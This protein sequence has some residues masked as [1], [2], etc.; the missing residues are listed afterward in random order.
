MRLSKIK[1]AG[2]K[3]F[4]D[5]TTIS[6]PS[7]LVGIVGPNGCG[8]SNVIDAV[9][10]VMGES[11]AKHLRGDSMADVIFNG[12][13]SRKPVGAATIELC[14]DNSDGSIGGEYAQYSEIAIKRS[15]GR[16]GLSQYFLN[17]TRCRRKDITDIFLGTGLGAR[18]YAII[19]QGMVSRLVDAKPDDMRTYIEEAAGISKYKERRRE[20]ENRIQ[21]TRDNLARLNDLREEVAKQIDY[22]QR[23]AKT[24][25]R[26]K[27]LKARERQLEAELFA[28]RLR[29]LDASLHQQRADLGRNE[30][31]LEAAVAE[32][33]GVEAEIIVARER[34]VG[35]TESFNA[36]QARFYAVQSE[37]SRLEQTIAHSRELAERRASDLEQTRS[38]LAEIAIEIERDSAQLADLDQALE[39]LDPDIARARQA[40]AAAVARFRDAEEALDR[41]QDAWHAFNLELK[42]L[43]Q[44]TQVE[45]TRIEHLTAQSASVQRQQETLES[46]RGGLAADDFEQQLQDRASAETRLAGEV[47][48]VREQLAGI[49]S[50]IEQLRQRERELGAELEG[51]LAELSSQ[52]GQ[53]STLMAVQQAALGAEQG[54]LTRWLAGRHLD[55][56]PRLAQRLQVEEGWIL[57]VETVLGD[58]L[59]AVCVAN[60]AEHLE[61]LPDAQVHLIS[62]QI[63]E[64]PYD[65]GTLLERVQRAGS[66]A[67]ILASVRVADSLADAVAIQSR[68]GVHE[69]V[70]TADGIWLGHGWARINRG[71]RSAGGLLSRASDLRKLEKA[72]T[73]NEALAAT[74]ERARHE[75]WARLADL[76]QTRNQTADRFTAANREHAEAVAVLEG[77][78]QQFSRARERGTLIEQTSA[79]VRREFEELN[80]AIAGAKARLE[81]ARTN[82][83]AQNARQPAL[84]LQQQELLDAYNAAGAQVESER[85]AL[86]RINVEYEGRRVARESLAAALAKLTAQSAQLA[87]R[88]ESLQAE[89]SGA[90]E[91]LAETRRTLE[92]RLADQLLIEKDLTQIREALEAVESALRA[93]ESRRQST[94]KSVSLARDAAEALRMQVRELEVRR[95]TLLE[96]FAATG[97]VL[98]EVTAT[99][100]PDADAQ[101]WTE[102]LEEARRKIERLGPINLAAIDQFSEQS[103]R[104]KYLDAQDLD[105][106]TALDTLEQ[107]IRKIDRET[108]SRFQE[109]F[110]NINQ[111]LKRIFPRL[112]GGG[113]A[114]LS[115]EGD[116]TLAAGVT[117]MARPPGKRNSHIHLLSGGEKALTAVALI[118][119]IFELNPAPFCLLDE[120][121]APLDEANV[122]RFCEI[123]REMSERVQFMVI[124][125]NKT[126]ME[127]VNQLTGVTMNEPG[128]SRLVSVDLD[129]A[130]RLVA[131]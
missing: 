29:D 116:D 113:H 101:R 90:E 19:E 36:T 38:Q 59:E 122:G 128:V 88:G 25:E 86:G 78:R 65:A 72:V 43:N 61:D 66:A 6:L 9:R 57:A 24:A 30:T 41:W 84:Q 75:L 3:S 92:L 91:P 131:N 53:V 117:V 62:D 39:S 130:V 46:E 27:D 104:K 26:Y 11:S 89:M 50:E 103:E 64:R 12:S 115:L 34:H 42:E 129:E 17:N 32:Q 49:D 31:G 10:W 98:D 69:S 124:T 48:M 77:L 118:F 33:R 7:S 81:E 44:Q 126:T 70:I 109:T 127:M 55:G 102:S 52:R 21:H 108:R 107:A 51:V 111:G 22:L 68:L 35:A 74:S 71:K 110:E 18:S 80:S 63:P 23:Q 54:P 60:P 8:K 100:A 119:S 40:D 58:F 67:A 85:E 1:L 114:Y 95:E 97:A 2:F 73:A 120:V 99:L 83:S 106:T 47:D 16:D 20:T 76:E 112:F 37:A 93:C 5:P 94:D 105:L 96:Q 4:V 123:V 87:A 121:D 15:I 125:H 45:Q 56:R 79:S 14:F 82:L 13:A 28:I